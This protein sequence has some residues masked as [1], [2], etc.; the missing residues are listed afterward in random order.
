[1]SPNQCWTKIGSA[2]IEWVIGFLDWWK[3]LACSGAGETS[4]VILDRTATDVP[5][6]V[7]LKI[8]CE[9]VFDSGANWLR[10][11]VACRF[12]VAFPGHSHA[13]RLIC[14]DTAGVQALLLHFSL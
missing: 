1:M 8:I 10:T 2:V 9:W 6:V 3:I 4:R 14:L 12:V 7:T 13:Y 5:V 11:G